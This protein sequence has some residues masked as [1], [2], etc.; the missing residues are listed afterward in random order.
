MAGYGATYRL[1]Q[2]G[3]TPDVYDK[4]AYPFGHTVSYE[5]KEAGFVFDDGPHVSFTKDKRIQG[6]FAEF[7]GGEYEE[8]A[9][10]VNNWWRDRWIKHPCIVNLHGLPQEI[11]VDC[12]ADFIAAQNSEPPE[13]NNYEDWLLASYGRTYYEQFPRD[14]T[15]RYHTVDPSQ[16]STDW[17]A[18]RLYQADIKEVLKGAFNPETED[19]HYIKGFRYPKGGGFQSYMKPFT[20]W[21]DI[22]LNHKV[23]K[24]DP[25]KKML[26]FANGSEIDYDYLISSIALPDLLK[27]VEGAPQDVLRAVERLGCTSC[28]LVNIGMNN[29]EFTKAHWTYFYDMDYSFTRLSFPHNLSKSTC[30]DGCGAIQAEVYFSNKYKP[31]VGEP[32]DYIEPVIRDLKR[33]GLIKDDNEIIFQNATYAEYA[34][35]IFDLERAENLAIVHGYL[36]DVGIRYCGRYGDWGYMWTD[37]SFKSGEDAAQSILDE[38]S[39]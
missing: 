37:D 33:C 8:F 36:D 2:E 19:V 12:I 5:H 25:S 16:M 22:Q 26:S 29:D 31:M 20:E 18:Q 24:V 23:V 10:Y 13:I 3:I 35:V 9:T 28:V 38:A 7:V 11:L 27:M 15:I 6:L 30:P 32:N 1:R 17:M 14:Y 21:V 4:N 34:N 39:S